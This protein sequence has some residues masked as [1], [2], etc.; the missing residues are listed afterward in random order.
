MTT[1]ID[2]VLQL[3]RAWI[4]LDDAH[5]Y[6]LIK[7]IYRITK[8]QPLTQVTF[9]RPM[10][11]YVCLMYWPYAG[12]RYVH[13]TEKKFMLVELLMANYKNTHYHW[14]RR[15]SDGVFEMSEA[16]PCTSH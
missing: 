14:Q 8:C 2:P 16:T 6:D 1:R 7:Q 12:R 13:I 4:A 15:G 10:N 11:S 5:R 9:N 3:N